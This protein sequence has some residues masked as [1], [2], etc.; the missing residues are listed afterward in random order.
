MALADEVAADIPAMDT[1][2]L[3]RGTQ[4]FQAWALRARF[5]GYTRDSRRCIVA[6]ARSHLVPLAVVYLRYMSRFCDQCFKPSGR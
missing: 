1:A 4:V 6:C 5:R 3:T 2:E